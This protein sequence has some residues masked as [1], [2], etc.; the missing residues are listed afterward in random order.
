MNVLAKVKHIDDNAALLE[1]TKQINVEILSNL[2]V[3][4]F[5]YD[6]PEKKK[7]LRKKKSKPV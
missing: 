7:V 5:V 3:L 4:L 6:I 1:A 2:F